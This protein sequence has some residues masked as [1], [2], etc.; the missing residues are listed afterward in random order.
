MN[1]F[2]FSVSLLL[3]IHHVR[4][5]HLCS[6][7][8]FEQC[9]LASWKVGELNLG[10]KGTGL[11]QFTSL[12]VYLAK[13]DVFVEENCAC[14]YVN[15]HPVLCAVC[16]P[17][18]LRAKQILPWTDA[19]ALAEMQVATFSLGLQVWLCGFCCFAIEG[20]LCLHQPHAPVPCLVLLLVLLWPFSLPVWG[21]IQLENP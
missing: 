20:L 18:S 16:V 7:L 11:V 1:I 8:H 2:M 4:L 6:I 17:A 5:H 14:S 3:A 19:S 12:K 9:W 15:L 21:L 13:S 10:R